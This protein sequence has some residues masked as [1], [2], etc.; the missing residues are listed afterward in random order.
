MSKSL[1]KIQKDIDDFCEERGWN[2]THPNSL[3]TSTL[4]E[5]GELAEHYQWKNEFEEYTEDEKKEIAYE[6]VD[7]FFYLSRL[8]NKTGINIEEAFYD[9]L[10]KL[11][12]KFPI[13]KDSL[14]ANKEYR[15]A[16]KNKL[17]D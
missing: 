6:F 8:A 1:T 3:I 2:H 17:Y 16:G 10:P 14:E 5:L 9:K 12:K 4:I 7:V 13:G 11:A 15:A